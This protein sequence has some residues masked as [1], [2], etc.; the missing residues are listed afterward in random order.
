MQGNLRNFIKMFLKQFLIHRLIFLQGDLS[1]KI[2][3]PAKY[4]LMTLAKSC[5]KVF[6]RRRQ[7]QL[8]FL[9][10]A[11]NAIQNPSVLEYF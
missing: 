10:R 5:E 9:S 7:S 1:L 8:T 6:E 2:M 4:I 11:P 3:T